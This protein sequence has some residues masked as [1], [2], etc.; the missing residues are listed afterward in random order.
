MYSSNA[1]LLQ[2]V[3]IAV[4]LIIITAP[5]GAIGIGLSAPLL[6]DREPSTAENDEESGLSPQSRPNGTAQVPV[7]AQERAG[8]L[9]PEDSNL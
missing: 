3:T 4:L 7:D 5:L 8:M 9:T 6:L 1:S 2:V